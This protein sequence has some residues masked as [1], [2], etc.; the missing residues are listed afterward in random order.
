MIE[1]ILIAKERKP[2]FAAGFL[3]IRVREKAHSLSLWFHGRAIN[4]IHRPVFGCKF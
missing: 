1:D 2:A 4:H 3:I